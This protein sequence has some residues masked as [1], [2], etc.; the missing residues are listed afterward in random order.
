MIMKRKLTQ[1]VLINSL[2]WVI[3][4]RAIAN[5][6]VVENHLNIVAVNHLIDLNDII[7]LLILAF[8]CLQYKNL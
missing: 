2:I 3:K 7:M 1:L 4:Y 6:L 8:N 5:H